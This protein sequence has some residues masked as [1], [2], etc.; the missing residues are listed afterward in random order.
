M[1]PI[2]CAPTVST[3][4][5]EE[6]RTTVLCLWSLCLK[7]V[8]GETLTTINPEHSKKRTSGAVFV[9]VFVTVN[10]HLR[11]TT[12]FVLARGLRGDHLVHIGL[13]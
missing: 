12:P 1:C 4:D 2:L 8:W 5:A 7:S 11:E 6:N 10:K 9:L 13:W 3:G